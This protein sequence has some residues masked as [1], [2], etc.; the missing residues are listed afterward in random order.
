MKVEQDP[1]LSPGASGATTDPGRAALAAESY[2]QRQEHGRAACRV[3]PRGSHAVW[4]PAPDRPD[5][6]DFLEAQAGTGFRAGNLC[7]PLRLGAG[8]GARPLW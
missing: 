1:N 7:R 2:Q 6:V 4:A 8:P 3:A 5:P